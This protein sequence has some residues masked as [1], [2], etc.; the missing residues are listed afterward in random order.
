ML[1]KPVMFFFLG[2]LAIT[3]DRMQTFHCFLALHSALNNQYND[4]SK[5]VLCENTKI[6]TI[7]ANNSITHT[8]QVGHLP[9]VRSVSS[10][11]QRCHCLKWHIFIFPF[12]ASSVSSILSTLP[13]CVFFFHVPPEINL[14]KKMFCL[15]SKPVEPPI[16]EKNGD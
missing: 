16:L 11:P 9:R 8:S 12:M 2:Y 6:F 5:M 15:T 13:F 1:H 7:L 3:F 10:F 4:I 14:G